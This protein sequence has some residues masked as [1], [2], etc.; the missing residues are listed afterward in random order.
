MSR[1]P[2]VH[3]ERR[4]AAAHDAGPRQGAAA[5][6][7]CRGQIGYQDMG[8]RVTRYPLRAHG[9]DR[10]RQAARRPARPALDGRDERRLFLPVP[11]R[12][13]EH[14]PA[15][16]EGNGGRA[17]LGLQPLA[18]REG[19]AGI[20]Q[21]LLLDAVPAVLRSRRVRCARSRP[22]ATA[23]ASTGFMVTTVRNLPVHDNSLHEGLS[24]DRGA[25]PVARRSTP[26]SNWSEPVFKGLQP[27]HL[28]ARARLLASTTSCTAPTG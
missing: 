23:R 19:A 6:H 12:H 4:A 24:R 21:P 20:R 5:Q 16:A 9:K 3:G 7:R 18:H 1:D 10:A 27:L 2:A 28:G 13:A 11:D 14:R 22:S 8:G 15:S 26:A 25:R 17:V